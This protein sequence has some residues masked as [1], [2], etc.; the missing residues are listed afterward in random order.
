MR[1]IQ[2]FLVIAIVAL[3]ANAPHTQGAEASTCLKPALQATKAALGDRRALSQLYDT[4]FGEAL[5]KRPVARKWNRMSIV[6]RRLQVAHAKKFVLTLSRKFARYAI[7]DFA[8]KNNKAFLTLGKEHTT[9]QVFMS[10]MGCMMS[11]ICIQS[12]GCLSN[13]IGDVSK[14]K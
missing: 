5:A 2:Y 4:Y 6:E 11:D 7:A 9:M 13:Y 8:W 14:L 10:G 3:I 1:S 12:S